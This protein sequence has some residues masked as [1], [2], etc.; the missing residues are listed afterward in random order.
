MSLRRGYSGGMEPFLSRRLCAISRRLRATAQM[1][2]AKPPPVAASPSAGVEGKSLAAMRWPVVN[3]IA[4]MAKK[5][6]P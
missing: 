4:P 1:A 5:A 2:T 3:Q 6:R